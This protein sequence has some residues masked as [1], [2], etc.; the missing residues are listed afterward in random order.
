MLRRK[1]SNGKRAGVPEYGYRY[2]DPLTGRWPSRDPIEEDGGVNLYGFIENDG[3]GYFDNLGRK[4]QTRQPTNKTA[5]S[6]A[7][8]ITDDSKARD[9]IP[10]FE[11]FLEHSHDLNP[12]HEIKDAA[13]AFWSVQI[14]ELTRITK[15]GSLAEC[16]GG[17]GFGKVTKLM[18]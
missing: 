4:K 16:V 18:V 6:R 17:F 13:T 2:Y 11:I 1:Y 15:Y 8:K 14:I 3:I 5:N 12:S 10:S 7:V 9:L